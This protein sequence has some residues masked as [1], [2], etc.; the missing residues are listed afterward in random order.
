MLEY[1]G[2]KSP[3]R[4]TIHIYK[5]YTMLKVIFFDICFPLEAFLLAFTQTNKHDTER[6]NRRWFANNFFNEII[7]KI[8]FNQNRRRQ[9]A[10]TFYYEIIVKKMIFNQRS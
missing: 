5:M 9:V 7:V 8:K 10:S 2:L 1:I 4:N 6:K 3:G